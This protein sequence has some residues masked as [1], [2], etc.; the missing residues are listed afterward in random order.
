MVAPRILYV[1]I[2]IILYVIF[3]ETDNFLILFCRLFY[4]LPAVYFIYLDSVIVFSKKQY[5]FSKKY[6]ELNYN[7]FLINLFVIVF[8]YPLDYFLFPQMRVIVFF[9][10]LLWGTNIA[11]VKTFNLIFPNESCLGFSKIYLFNREAPLRFH[12]PGGRRLNA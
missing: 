10:L 3:V 2:Y 4:R 5:I 6:F 1:Y 8:L 12:N 9:S 11:L 7:Q